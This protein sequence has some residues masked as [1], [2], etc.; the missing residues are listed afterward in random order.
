MEAEERRDAAMDM[1]LGAIRDLPGILQFWHSAQP[2][3]QNAGSQGDA[4][5]PVVAVWFAGA[6]LLE[7]GSSVA[8]YLRLRSAGIPI[9]WL[10]YGFPGYLESRYISWRRSRNESAYLAVF[11]RV[12]SLLN[13]V[14]AAIV[15]IGQH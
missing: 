4:M 2:E 15:F 7:V 14:A 3:H 13:L 12:A 9:S 1:L 5:I 11:L 6:V 8:L 10:R